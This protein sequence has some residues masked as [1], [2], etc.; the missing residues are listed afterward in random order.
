MQRTLLQNWRCYQLNFK[1]SDIL[2]ISRVFDQVVIDAMLQGMT[3]RD[4]LNYTRT[5]MNFFSNI[6]Q[7]TLMLNGSRFPTFPVATNIK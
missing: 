2:E 6:L 4:K 3:D 7:V 5:S 1:N